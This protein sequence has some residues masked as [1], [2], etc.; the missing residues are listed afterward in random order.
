MPDY[1]AHTFVQTDDTEFATQFATCVTKRDLWLTEVQNESRRDRQNTFILMV[2]LPGGSERA[3]VY[4]AGT[5]IAKVARFEARLMDNATK[6]ADALNADRVDEYLMRYTQ[7]N[8][9]IQMAEG[10][11]DSPQA[12]EL[13]KHILGGGSPFAISGRTNLEHANNGHQLSQAHLNYLI[14]KKDLIIAIKAD[15]GNDYQL[16]QWISESLATWK[17]ADAND[18]ILKL[19]P[20]F[21]RTDDGEADN[22]LTATLRSTINPKHI[23][24]GARFNWGTSPNPYA[25]IAPTNRVDL[26]KGTENVAFSTNL[27][28]L[29]PNTEYHF[30]I[31]AASKYLGLFFGDDKTFTTPQGPPIPQVEYTFNDSSEGGRQVTNQIDNGSIAT[32]G[33]FS[34]NTTVLLSPISFSELQITNAS[35]TIII[36]GDVFDVLTIGNFGNDEEW[37]AGRWDITALVFHPSQTPLVTCQI[38]IASSDGLSFILNYTY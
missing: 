38:D 12:L 22:D 2:V 20:P 30:Q 3:L 8:K 9:L 18:L 24:V 1:I 10:V 13:F 4:K 33:G 37:N 19:L 15:I 25:H 34:S 7:Q 27:G 36:N 28:S 5:N 11:D 21:V 17:L 14:S 16:V 31:V 32:E 29:D 35:I 6:M 23:Q 26:G